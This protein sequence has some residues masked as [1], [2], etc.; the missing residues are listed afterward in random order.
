MSSEFSWNHWLKRFSH[1]NMIIEDCTKFW[2]TELLWKLYFMNDFNLFNKF[3]LW[4]V[5]RCLGVSSCVVSSLHLNMISVSSKVSVSW[6][7]NRS[8]SFYYF[9]LFCL[10]RLLLHFIFHSIVYSFKNINLIH[11]DLQLFLQSCT[12]YSS[13]KSH[14]SASNW[15][16]TQV[17]CNRALRARVIFEN[18][19]V[20]IDLSIYS[21]HWFDHTSRFNTLNILSAWHIHWWIWNGNFNLFL[22]SL[23]CY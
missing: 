19:S 11:F 23:M 1:L 14:C 3:I 6:G 22:F 17:Y 2:M 20:D 10:L 21:K 7:S 4:A 12:C 9:I 16:S 8:K 5:W 15:P 13:L 18:H